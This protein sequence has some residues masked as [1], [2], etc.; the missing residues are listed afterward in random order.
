MA[1]SMKGCRRRTASPLYADENS[2]PIE[3]SL[4]INDNQ[5]HYEVS[6]KFGEVNYRSME[7]RPSNLSFSEL[8]LFHGQINHSLQNMKENERGYNYWYDLASKG[9]DLYVHLFPVEEVREAITQ[10]YDLLHNTR[11]EEYIYPPCKITV[12]LRNTRINIPWE[13]LYIAG[14]APNTAENDAESFDYSRFLGYYFSPTQDL[15]ETSGFYRSLRC[16]GTPKVRAYYCDQLEVAATKELSFLRQLASSEKISLDIG[17]AYQPSSAVSLSQEKASFVSE[18]IQDDSSFVH[19]ACHSG[20]DK[21]THDNYFR[22]RDDFVVDRR[23]FISDTQPFLFDKILF[24]NSCELS[25]AWSSNYATLIR[26]LISI[27]DAYGVLATEIEIKDEDAF[28]FA[29]LLFSNLLQTNSLKMAIFITRRQI[30]KDHQSMIGF[31]YSF[32]A[33]GD[34]QIIPTVDISPEEAKAA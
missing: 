20:I 29:S 8:E 14:P 24:F 3:I 23:D 5:I 30:L 18:L 10:V 32:Y 2:S 1:R 6:V 13:L 21:I 26:D 12:L 4:F 15:S 22:I 11:T 33:R 19:F 16:S 28:L 7:R 27:K 17:R 31:T 25:Q 34:Y 9:H